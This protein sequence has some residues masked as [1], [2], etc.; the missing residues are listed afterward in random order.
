[1]HVN[2]KPA[3]FDSYR[4]LNRERLCP[5]CE[6]YGDGLG[7]AILPRLTP[8]EESVMPMPGDADC[9]SHCGTRRVAS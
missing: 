9:C 8:A 7:S 4:V 5:L 6:S 2:P 1:M 3:D